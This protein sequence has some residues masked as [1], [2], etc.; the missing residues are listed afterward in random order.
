MVCLVGCWLKEKL[1]SGANP[2][3]IRKAALTF[4]FFTIESQGEEIKVDN[5]T[6]GAT[7]VNATMRK[8]LVSVIVTRV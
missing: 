8:I 6:C 5:L 4:I 3:S 7:Q 2:K 1:A